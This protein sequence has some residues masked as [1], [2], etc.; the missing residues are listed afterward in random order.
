MPPD[1]SI[2]DGSVEPCPPERDQVP[3]PP[4]AAPDRSD[5]AVPDGHVLPDRVIASSADAPTL[6]LWGYRLCGGWFCHRTG[7]PRVIL[8]EDGVAVDLV[9]HHAKVTGKVPAGYVYVAGADVGGV[10]EAS[11]KDRTAQICPTVVASLPGWCPPAP[12]LR[13]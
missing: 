6:V 9:N 13:S 7:P 2:G 10:T 8:A 3:I 4:L 11:L 1:V 12:V 5:G